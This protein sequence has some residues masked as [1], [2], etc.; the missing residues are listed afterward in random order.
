MRLI[1]T[2]LAIL[3]A[4]P[5]GA[6]IVTILP[7]DSLYQSELSTGVDS[8]GNVNEYCDDFAFPEFPL[9]LDI[10]R[11]FQIPSGGSFVDAWY[12]VDDEGF[13]IE[14]DQGALANA[15]QRYSWTN[16][17]AK[18]TVD[19]EIQY[20]TSGHICF[21]QPAGG[22]ITSIQIFTFS[23]YNSSTQE[24]VYSSYSHD[25][26]AG[27]PDSADGCHIL[28]YPTGPEIGLRSGILSPGDT[29][30]LRLR[31][32]TNGN[33]FRQG[34][35]GLTTAT[36]KIRLDFLPVPEPGAA[37]QLLSASGLLALLRYLSV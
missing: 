11:H 30:I 24:V 10:E 17:D 13:S 2:L 12:T 15:A 27:Q 14:F 16:L 34:E 20:T 31:A 1:I 7:D 6:W 35:T 21:T 19:E 8:C 26:A 29:Y 23:L 9:P 37:L 3:I 33:E 32:G 25:G 18:F 4:A 28:W 22:D 36:G 5:A